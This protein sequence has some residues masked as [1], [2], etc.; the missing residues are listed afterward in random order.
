MLEQGFYK[1]H[2][3]L[4]DRRYT[5]RYVWVKPGDFITENNI[6][7][8]LDDEDLRRDIIEGKCE[9]TRVNKLPTKGLKVLQW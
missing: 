1:V 9:V 5:A 8:L 3:K 2:I 4:E 6:L 7:N